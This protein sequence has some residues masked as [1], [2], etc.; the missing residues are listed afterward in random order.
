MEFEHLPKDILLLSILERPQNLS[1]F[2][3][4]QA[5]RNWPSGAPHVKIAL[6]IIKTQILIL[7]HHPQ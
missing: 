4:I 5:A 3:L 7:R 6:M 1:K 2:K